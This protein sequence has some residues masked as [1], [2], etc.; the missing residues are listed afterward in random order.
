M[1]LEPLPERL[2]YKGVVADVVS[3]DGLLHLFTY[4]SSTLG[5]SDVDVRSDSLSCFFSYI[6]N[7]VCYKNLAT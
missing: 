3:F 6:N 4:C 7:G 5:I 2:L 1:V